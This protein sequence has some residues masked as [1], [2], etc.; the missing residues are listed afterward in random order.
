MRCSEA[1]RRLNEYWQQELEKVDDLELHRHLRKCSACARHAAAVRSLRRDFAA[2]R[3]HDLGGGL[4]LSILKTRV[5]AHAASPATFTTSEEK[6][7]MSTMI[8]GLKK[9]SRLSATVAVAAVVLAFLTL[10]PFSFEQTVGYEVA[11]AGVDKDLA[12]DNNRVQALLATLGME[13][14]EFDVTDCE[15]TCNLVVRKLG[16][17]EDADLVVAAFKSGEECLVDCEISMVRAEG[18]VSLFSQAKK[19]IFVGDKSA[20]DAGIKEELIERLGADCGGDAFV[21]M[22]CLSDSMIECNVNV[23]SEGDSVLCKKIAIACVD[24]AQLPGCQSLSFGSLTEGDSIKKCIMIQGAGGGEMSDLCANLNLED[25]ELSEETIQHLRDMGC[26]VTIETSPDGTTKRIEIKCDDS[27]GLGGGEGSA[28]SSEDTDLPDGYALE[29]NYPNPFNPTTTIGFSIPSSQHVTLEI[30]NV[31]GQI[32]RTLIDE[33]RGAGEHSVEWDATSDGG[34]RVASGV[35]FY[36]LT[37]GDMVVAKK[38][39]LLK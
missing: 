11:V 1:K 19:V 8:R 15:A 21:W 3:G 17:Q 10:V 30:Y 9:R 13:E 28:K 2:A 22:Q 14:A 20:D 34:D 27:C 29:Q 39:T 25:G 26:D 5:E 38:M 16:S 7:I 37:T 18:S 6:S 31:Q 36:R 12:L 4:P 32:V 23:F 24:S 33:V 35:Y